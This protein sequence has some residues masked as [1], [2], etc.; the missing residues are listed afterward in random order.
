ML[1]ALGWCRVIA[2]GVILI[3]V[4]FLGLMS[5]WANGIE[6]T[7]PDDVPRATA[8]RRQRRAWARERRQAGWRP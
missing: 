5:A 1:D 2:I 8:T 4:V 3:A 7:I 6:R